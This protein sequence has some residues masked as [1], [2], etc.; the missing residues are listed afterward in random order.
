MTGKQ[1]KD[2]LPKFVDY[3]NVTYLKTFLNPHARMLAS[4]KSKV[5]A[6]HQRKIR[7]AIKRARFMG[8]LPFIAR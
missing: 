4:R 5:P 1:I 6:F 2:T 3:K 8:L 7:E